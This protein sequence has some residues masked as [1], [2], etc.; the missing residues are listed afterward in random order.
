MIYF[1]TI[2]VSLVVPDFMV[3]EKM[4]MLP[5]LTFDLDFVT[6]TL[7]TNYA[8]RLLAINFQFGKFDEYS[9]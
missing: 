3:L 8:L 6:F 4:A 9:L 5:W 2:V 1:N 7:V